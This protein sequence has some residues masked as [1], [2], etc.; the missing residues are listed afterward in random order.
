MSNALAIAATS[1]VLQ[2]LLHELYANS[3]SNLGQVTV[4][5]IAPDIVQTNQTASPALQVNL[6]LHQVTPNAAWRNVDMPSVSANGSSRLRN[7]PLALDLHYLLTAYGQKNFEAE[8][9]LG[10]AVQFLH[11][12]P[13]VAR[14]DIRAML[15]PLPAVGPPPAVGNANLNVS[16]LADQVEMLKITP[17]T[18]GREEMAWIWT[19]LKA[20]YRPTFP[21]QVTVVLI[22]AENAG[23]SVLP[24]LKR[25]IK[26]Q[27]DLL[28]SFPALTAVSPPSYQPAAKPGD[29]VTVTGVNLM[30]VSQV[31]LS[32]ARLGLNPT[33]AA[34]N[35]EA[36][37]F[38]FTI[39]NP[40]PPSPPTAP[41]PPNYV[42]AGV[43]LLSVQGATQESLTTNSL[44]FAAAPT[45]TSV[46]TSTLGGVFTINIMC[47]PYVWPGQQVSLLVGGQSAFPTLPISSAVN[48]L[49]FNFKTL[50]PSPTPILL[51]LRVDGVDSQI[52]DMTK[53]PPIF[54]GPTVV[55]T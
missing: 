40:L 53:K 19:A 51:R 48:S 54:S 28:L 4:S 47:A 24:V 8:A 30:A 29:V 45:I 52:I 55:V 42:P 27:P 1:A 7:Q 2:S 21:F 13:V 46:T 9:L 43:Y 18:L 20:D 41:N 11:E 35:V 23:T 44:A 17:A 12:T 32:N 14:N 34:S 10:Y 25:H 31:V 39:P 5:A 33:I 38:Q 49:S 50:P 37:S 3:A 6:F 15:T 26:V 22:L 36:G 16:G